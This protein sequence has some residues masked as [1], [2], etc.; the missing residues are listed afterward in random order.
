M[1]NE[2]NDVFTPFVYALFGKEGNPRVLREVGFVKSMKIMLTN[3]ITMT[4]LAPS[5]H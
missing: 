5:S 4:Y 2:I 3:R 1:E